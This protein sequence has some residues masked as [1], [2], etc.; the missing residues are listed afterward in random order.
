MIPL[1][2]DIRKKADGQL[3]EA[4]SLMIAM[5]SR[6]HSVYADLHLHLP[7]VAEDHGQIVYPV[8]GDE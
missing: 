4:Q 6:K 7:K 2:E 8:R 1:G 5:R 3:P